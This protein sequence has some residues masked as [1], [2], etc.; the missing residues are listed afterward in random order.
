MRLMN[1][2]TPVAWVGLCF[3][4]C[5]QVSETPSAVS[6]VQT[7]QASSSAVLT[8]HRDGGFAGF[9]DELTISASGEVEAKSC[10]SGQKKTGKLSNENLGRFD[11]WRSSF[12]SVAISTKDAAA[13]DGMSITLDLKGTGSGQPGESERQEMLDWVSRIY[14]QL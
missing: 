14:A 13:A 3:A 8:W 11:R 1:S 7:T 10:R 6:Q 4:A 2:I 9:C 12:G 5:S